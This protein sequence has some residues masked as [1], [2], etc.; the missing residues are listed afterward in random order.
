VDVKEIGRWCP[1][2]QIT[3]SVSAEEL[4]RGLEWGNYKVKDLRSVV[5]RNCATELPAYPRDPRHWTGAPTG[6]WNPMKVIGARWPQEL[7]PGAISIHR[8][9]YDHWR[10]RCPAEHKFERG[11]YGVGF[12]TQQDCLS[13]AIIHGWAQHGWKM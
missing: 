5:C 2:C 6:N 13:A 11:G 12:K 9:I 3:T 7:R 8:D 1:R 10:W 4:R